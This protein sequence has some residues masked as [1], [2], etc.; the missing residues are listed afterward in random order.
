M[1]LAGKVAIVTGASRGIGR[2]I[3]R[4]LAREGADVAV[5]FVEHKNSAED[6]A[7]CIRESGRRAFAIRAD[8][9]DYKQVKEMIERV[10][11]EWGTI[12]ILVNNAGIVRDRTIS[13]MTHDEWYDV[14]AVDLTGI[15]NCTRAVI[16][17][18]IEQGSGRIVN[19]A[20]IVGMY[21]NFG[22]VNYAAAKAGVMGF[23][24]A[25]AREVASKGITVN[26]VA[27]GFIETGMLEGIPE[28]YKKKILA[29]IPMG[30]FGK[31]EDV[32]EVVTFLVSSKST[33]AT[34]Q[35]F[36]VDGGFY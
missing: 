31:P 16:G 32:A 2:A 8:V 25:L 6:V 19:I 29:R 34:G 30:K 17:K 5:N 13:K 4:S 21:G 14:L 7:R 23:T 18:M 36:C 15:F 11:S 35:V 22:Q 33:Y 9:R 10:T 12:D 24:K 1:K 26:A 28:E 3:A 20:S 27:P